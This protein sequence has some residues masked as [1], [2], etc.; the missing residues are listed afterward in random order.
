M[1]PCEFCETSKNTFL[2]ENSRATASICTKFEHKWWSQKCGWNVLRKR[3]TK[4]GPSFG[5]KKSFMIAVFDK[6]S[7]KSSTECH[8]LRYY[9]QC[10]FPCSVQM[11]H[12]TGQ[13]DS[14]YGHF[15]RRKSDI[16]SFDRPEFEWWGSSFPLN[17]ILNE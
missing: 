15:L 17:D 16:I 2:I 3:G 13:I 1:F 7:T 14:K 12:N 6:F 9:L 10:K 11:R 4:F 5:E 8:V